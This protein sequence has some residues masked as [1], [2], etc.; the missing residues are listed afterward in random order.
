MAVAKVVEIIAG[1]RKSFDDAVKEGLARAAETVSDITGAWVKD[2][3]VIVENGRITE[4]RVVLKV[5]FMLRGKS[6]AKKR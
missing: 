5:T 2:Q 6:G 3:N 4:Y 1:S